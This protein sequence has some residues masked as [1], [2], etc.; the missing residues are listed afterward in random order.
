LLFQ[1]QLVPLQLGV[2]ALEDSA[3]ASVGSREA[4]AGIALLVVEA[5]KGDIS[6]GGGDIRYVQSSL[7]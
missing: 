1:I 3:A 7:P 5:A 4:E 6:G 2:R